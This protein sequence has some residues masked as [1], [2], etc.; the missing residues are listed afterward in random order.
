MSRCTFFS[1]ESGGKYD[2]TYIE[3]VSIK[4]LFTFS[5]ANYHFFCNLPPSIENI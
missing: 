3:L 1:V 5:L 2:F 4:K